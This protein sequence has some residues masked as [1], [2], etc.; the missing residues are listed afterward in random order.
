MKRDII[1]AIIVGFIIGVIVAL[2]LTNLP[3]IVKEGIKLQSSKPIA[4]PTVI[5]VKNTTSSLELT[6]DLPKDESISDTKSIEVSG[7]TKASMTVFIES[8]IDQMTVE[9]NDAGGFAAKIN[10][11]E[12]V[13]TIFLT[14]Y[15]EAGNS[16]T[17]NL[18]I[19]YTTEK[20]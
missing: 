19:F 18:N 3:K 13:N 6:L 4:T 2:I 9:S 16:N 8:E 17:K 10:L 20:L 5:Q 12:G 15:D 11:S 1:L 14:V 7:Q